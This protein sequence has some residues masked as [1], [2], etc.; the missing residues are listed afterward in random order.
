M[1]H[2]SCVRGRAR[3]VMSLV[4]GCAIADNPNRS[5]DSSDDESL[6]V[7]ISEGGVHMRQR[8]DALR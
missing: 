2:P 1:R 7:A 4:R 5:I 3:A 6:R 8:L